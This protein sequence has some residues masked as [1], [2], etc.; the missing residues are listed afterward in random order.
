M[1]WVDFDYVS[2]RELTDKTVDLLAGVGIG[3]R[4]RIEKGPGGRRRYVIAIHS[5]DF[6]RAEKVRSEAKLRELEDFARTLRFVRQV[7]TDRDMLVS[8]EPEDNTGFIVSRVYHGEPFDETKFRIVG[9]GWDH[10]HC[11]L[12]YEKVLPDEEWWVAHPPDYEDAF[13]L[14][15]ACY[16]RLFGQNSDDSAART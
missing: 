7:F 16:G 2:T 4:Q 12:C 10:E 1:E 13:G 11:C 3:F 14:C 6:Q 8:L 9:G 5:E 15:L